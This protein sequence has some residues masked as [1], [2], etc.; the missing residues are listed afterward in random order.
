MAD[1][2]EAP[3]IPAAPARIRQQAESVRSGNPLE[4]N[5][6]I[7]AWIILGLLAGL[8]AEKHCFPGTIPG[9]SS[10]QR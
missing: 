10:S 5:M 9:V 3:F 1:D 7:I 2:E 8:I 6:G 4:V